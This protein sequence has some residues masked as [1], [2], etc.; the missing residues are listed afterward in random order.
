MLMANPE[1][2]Q[3]FVLGGLFDNSDGKIASLKAFT[4]PALGGFVPLSNSVSYPAG[5]K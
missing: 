2:G 5:G 1:I 3:T 4:L